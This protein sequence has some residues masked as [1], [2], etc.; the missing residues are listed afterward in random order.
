MSSIPQLWDWCY[1]SAWDGRPCPARASS[2]RCPPPIQTRHGT[3]PSSGQMTPNLRSPSSA[4]GSNRWWWAAARRPLGQRSSERYWMSPCKRPWSLTCSDRSSVLCPDRDSSRMLSGFLAF[5][6]FSL[7][8]PKKEA[9]FL[10]R[11]VCLFVCLS[12]RRITRKLVNGFWRN[13]WRGRAWLKDQYNFGGDPDHALDPGV[14]SP[15]SGSSRSAEVCALWVLLV[16]LYFNALLVPSV[17]WHCWLGSRKG[18]RPV[19]NWVVGCLHG[20]LS[21]ARCRF[22]YGPADAI[23]THYLLLQ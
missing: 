5:A 11:F 12:V 20:Y 21:A 1:P 6:I 7:P 13:F 19:Q 15:K 16:L 4:S 23:A 8:L 9:M 3:P 17:L 22:A 2:C 18:I 10:V 14:Q